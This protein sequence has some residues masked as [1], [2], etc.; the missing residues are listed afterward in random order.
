M[1]PGR[2]SSTR[3]TP[4]PHPRLARSTSLTKRP[5]TPAFLLR[6]IFKVAARNDFPSGTS[7]ASCR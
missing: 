5:P 2:P 1:R 6:G 7:C 3:P 4:R